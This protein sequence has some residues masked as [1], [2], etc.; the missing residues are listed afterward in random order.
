MPTSRTMG[1]AGPALPYLDPWMKRL[2]AGL[3]GLFVAEILAG[4]VGV[5]LHP[6]YYTGRDFLA[7]PWT[8]LTRLPFQG[9]Q[10]V[11]STALDLLVLYFFLPAL[12]HHLSRRQMLEALAATAAGS[13]A[14]VLLLD[15][16]GIGAGAAHGWGHLLVGAVALFGLSMPG[17]TVN[18]YFLIPI[19]A[20]WILWAALILPV[21][22]LLS[23]LGAGGNS[24]AS[25]QAVG[26]WGGAYA[27]WHGRGPGARRMRL[28]RKARTIERELRVF[29]GGRSRT[30][31]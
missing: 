3:A 31:H 12:A 6:L 25:V 24:L 16:I 20:R 14:A 17:A 28:K 11:V 27:W 9:P 2:L 8:L 5:Y 23:D 13:T 21:L 18:L 15:I 7:A 29:Q 10:A 1:P 26:A 19:Q 4:L 22:M 30:V